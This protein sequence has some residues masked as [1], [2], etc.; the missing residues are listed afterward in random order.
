VNARLFALTERVA[1]SAGGRAWCAHLAA[2][3]G[4][5]LAL[6]LSFAR[7]APLPVERWPVTEVVL[8]APPAPPPPPPEL[9]P[10]REP[11][12]PPPAAAAPPRRT[13]ERAPD[14]APVARAGALRT[15]TE[16]PDRP[17]EAPVRFVTDPN[18]RGYGTGIVAR[19]GLAEHGTGNTVTS[20]VAPVAMSE[21]ITPADELRKQPL[22]LGDG[23]RGFFPDQARPDRG[24]VSVIATVSANGHI[25]RLEV[26]SET[27]A[28]EGFGRAARACLAKRRFAPAL[29]ERGSPTGART[30]V[31]L[32]FTR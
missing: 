12:P 21:H 14:P 31:N 32:R 4:V 10:E 18:G 2:A 25:S 26:E 29:D 3:S 11:E 30:R 15:A 27:P 1:P 7:G 5:H 23:C 20:R 22:L 13:R 19:G 6:A 28:G 16:T 9:E 24:Q 17:D 8:E